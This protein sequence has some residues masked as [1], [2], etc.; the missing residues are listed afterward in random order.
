MVESG[1]WNYTTDLTLTPSWTV[2]TYSVT[3]DANG[4]EVDSESVSVDYGDE[5]ELPTPTR[6][7][8]TFNGWYNGTTLISDGDTWNYTTD[9]TLTASWTVNV[10]SLTFDEPCTTSKVTYNYNYT[11]STP[12][13]VTLGGGETLTYPTMPTRS[14]YVFT[15]WYTDSACTTKYDFTGT[16]TGDMTLY[17]GWT[18]MTM[19]YVYSEYVIDPSHYDYQSPN[20][21]F[22]NVSFNYTTS[23]YKNHVYLVANESGTHYIYY[24]TNSSSTSYIYYLQIYNLTKGTTIRSNSAVTSTSFSYSSFNCDE[25][26]IIVISIYRYNTSYSGETAHFYFDG[27]SG[28]TSSAV[29]N[30]YT[31]NVTYGS[32]VTLPTPTKSGYT[33]N[34]WYDEDGNL[35]ESGTWNYD[36]DMTLTADWTEN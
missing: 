15:G 13:T 6:T 24:R 16:I 19:S 14:G 36:K 25:G 23:S 26:D 35:V 29:N 4:G 17:A 32:D 11:G 18:E 9:I 22:L 10:Y 2:N 12:T 7:G 27:F 28:I 20:Y 21:Y 1:T 30:N 3:L 34:G 8:Y 31:Q 5:I 33:F